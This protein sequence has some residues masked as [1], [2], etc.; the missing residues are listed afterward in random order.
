MTRVFFLRQ[1][2][3]NQCL[4]IERAHAAAMLLRSAVLPIYDSVLM[5]NVLEMAG[6]F[7]QQVRAFRIGYSDKCGGLER[8]LAIR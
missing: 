3:D 6:T 5:S 4:P 2:A 1:A 8:L 7:A